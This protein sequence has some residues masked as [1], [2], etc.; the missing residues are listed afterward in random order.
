M[1]NKMFNL[2]SSLTKEAMGAAWQIYRTDDA[3]TNANPVKWFKLEDIKSGQNESWNQ[4]SDTVPNISSLVNF[5]VNDRNSRMFKMKQRFGKDSEDVNGFFYTYVGYSSTEGGYVLSIGPYQGLKEAQGLNQ[6]N[7]FTKRNTTATPERLFGDPVYDKEGNAALDKQGNP[8]YK[9]GVYQ[10]KIK[11]YFNEWANVLTPDDFELQVEIVSDKV[12][13]G[14]MKKAEQ[15]DPTSQAKAYQVTSYQ[16]YSSI[17]PDSPD[18]K[19]LKENPPYMGIG[20]VLQPNSQGLMKMIDHSANV[21]NF[22]SILDN[23]KA[24]FAA[25]HGKAPEELMNDNQDRKLAEA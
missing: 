2:K 12:T 17:S 1:T 9:D 18:G 10:K 3:T 19:K 23:V 14:K 20:S 16:G 4:L 21:G 6:F 15:V 25:K 24:E 5:A 11:E 13:I 22:E 7:F 8:V